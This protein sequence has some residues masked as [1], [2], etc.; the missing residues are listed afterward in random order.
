MR[1]RYVMQGQLSDYP[2]VGERIGLDGKT[3]RLP[4]REGEE[5]EESVE[6]DILPQNIRTAYL[7]R[8][9]HCRLL[10]TAYARVPENEEEPR[11]PKTTVP[12]MLST[13]TVPENSSV[14]AMGFVCR[15]TNDG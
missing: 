10:M 3:R 5:A 15:A 7:L 2:T 9:A 8:A 14:S 4:Q 6:D 11:A 13:W 12:L 1:R